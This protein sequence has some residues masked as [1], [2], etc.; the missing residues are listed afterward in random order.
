LT[1]ATRSQLLLLR[2]LPSRLRQPRRLAAIALLGVTLGLVLVFIYAR[3]ELAG[4]DAYAYWTAVHRW[5]SGQDIYQVLPGLYVPPSEGA[6]P[7]AYAPWSLY[8]FLPWALLPWDLAWVIWRAANIVAFA[9]SVAWAYERRPLGTALFVALVAPA[10]AANLDTGNINI[11][12]ALAVWVG[13]FSGPR[14]GGLAW[15][16]GASLKWVPAPLLL[17][18]PRRAWPAGLAV[19]GVLALLTL[20]SWPEVM[21]QADIVA[22]YP[23]PLRVDYMFLLWAALPWLWA[24]P[25]PPRL[26]RE[27]L[28]E[29]HLRG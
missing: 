1:D 26:S 25:W 5:L 12:I 21:R 22:N 13:W 6:L 29:F 20:A 19:F 15:A 28:K 14:L 4:A 18:V 27:W 23:R 2:G 3:H 16:F 24:R 9:L 10:L 8:L 11:F 7:Y 17:F